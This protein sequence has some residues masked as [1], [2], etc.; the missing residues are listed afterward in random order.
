MTA[1]VPWALLLGVAW[2][3]AA[4]GFGVAVLLAAAGREDRDAER[5]AR[6]RHPSGSRLDAEPLDSGRVSAT[7]RVIPGG[8]R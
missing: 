4:L 8:A 2:V 1:V 7:L 6:G 5:A 3:S